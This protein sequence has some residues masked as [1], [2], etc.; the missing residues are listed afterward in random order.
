MP[1]DGNII[2]TFHMSGK[3]YP[4]FGELLSPGL[5]TISR[6]LILIGFA[7]AAHLI[8]RMLRVVGDKLTTESRKPFRRKLG[9]VLSLVT[10]ALVFTLYFVVLGFVLQEFGIS[11]TGYLASATI[12]GLAVGFGSQGLVQDVV[13][14]LTLIFSDLFD[15][16]EMVE[17]S[18]QSGIVKSIG[19]RFVVLENSFGAAIYIPNRTVT[20]VIN[21]PRGYIRCIADVTLSSND[22]LAQKMEQIASAI[23]QGV[24]EQFPGILLT[25][26]SIEGRISTT[27]ARQFLR[28]KFRIWPGRGDPIDKTFRQ[29]VVAK[30]RELDPGYADWQVAVYFEVEQKATRVLNRK[31]GKGH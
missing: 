24:Y 6:V 28:I 27:A 7:I 21:Y 20:N 5:S 10:S 4:M 14:G 12:I 26:P 9:S 18:G 16:G 31:P 8:V 17:I 11:L 29:E 2:A 3:R 1:A 25:P 13:T 15:V 30:L 23:A 19:M 22:E